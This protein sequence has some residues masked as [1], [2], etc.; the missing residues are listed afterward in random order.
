MKKLTM[1]F[2]PPLPFVVITLFTFMIALGEGP[3]EARL[4]RITAGP[5]TLIDLPTFGETG[6][7]L[8]IAG[9]YEGELD[10]ADPRMP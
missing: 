6:A 9:T 1:C 10:P 7:Y 2:V 5:V 3:A 4:T 8:K